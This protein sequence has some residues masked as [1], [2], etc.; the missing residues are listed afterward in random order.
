MNPFNFDYVKDDY[1]LDDSFLYDDDHKTPTRQPVLTPPMSKG[2]NVDRLMIPQ[3]QQGLA[4]I[5]EI[6]K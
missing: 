2:K 4:S 5:H 1:L 3:Y 6:R